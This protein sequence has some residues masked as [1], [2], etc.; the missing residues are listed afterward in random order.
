MLKKNHI[1]NFFCGLGI[2]GLLVLSTGAWA[3]PLHSVMLSVPDHPEEALTWCGPATA[4]ML[5][6][7][8]PS[9]TCSVLQEDI[10]TEIQTYKAES[11]WDT[12][13]AGLGGAMK[14]LCPPVG[15]WSVHAKTDAQALM[16]DVAYWMNRMNYPVAGLLNTLPHNSYA[17]HAEHWVA[18][19]GIITDADPV[20]NP[21]VN[22]VFVWFND[23][24]VAL[25]D[26]SIERFI[27]GS[28]WYSEFQ[29]VTKPTSSY[30]GKY[31]AVIEPPQIKG[32]AVAP[33]EILKGKLITPG[34][35]VEQAAKWIEEYKLYEIGPYKLLK[36][37][38]P[39]PP[40]L[41]NSRYGGYYIVPFAEGSETRAEAAI[42]INA[43]TG[44]FQEAGVF[45]PRSFMSE[46]EARSIALRYAQAKKTKKVSAE[47]MLPVKERMMSRY[48]PFW[49]VIVDGRTVG[50][51]QQGQVLTK[52]P[53]E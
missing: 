44:G 46:K 6:E 31:V 5:M 11:M 20:M 10:W 18:I 38:K 25:G 49:K 30:S 40:L 23:P 21:T 53:K 39:L 16:Y 9:G 7:G 52:I 26:P 37:S 43:Y 13:P 48:F 34:S 42:L 27:S 24:A 15:T 4:Q 45:K 41:V 12:D 22:L 1:N 51:T 35:A 33:A 19:R 8:Y 47:L 2:M 36:K 32:K 14:H 3:G 28:T 50:V 17:A 29:P